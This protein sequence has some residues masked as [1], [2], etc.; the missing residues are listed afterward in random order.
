M[1]GFSRTG[2]LAWVCSLWFAVLLPGSVAAQEKAAPPAAKNKWNV[3]IVVHEGV[4]LLD[5]AGPGEVFAAAAQGRAFN[6]Y[7]VAET[8]KPITSQR[9]LKITPNY[10]IMDCPKPDILVIPGGQTNYLL[11]SPAMMAWVKKTAAE[12]DVLLTVCTGAFVA[13]ELGLLDG[14]EATTHHSSV[15]G[16]ANRYPKIKVRSDRRIV[17]N[18]KIVT[19]AGVSSGIDGSLHLVARLCG[20]ETA[21]DTAKYM[22]YRWEPDPTLTPR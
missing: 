9:F 13:A 8:T 21:K 6:V 10:S 15:Q 14:K 12:V 20:L 1:R 5:F 18:G 7:T 2:C 22:E 19:V 17:D 11:R 4:E 3:A 16:L